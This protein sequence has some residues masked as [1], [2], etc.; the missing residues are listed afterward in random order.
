[1]KK[2]RVIFGSSILLLLSS[3]IFV[4]TSYAFHS[5]DETS[6]K[7]NAV[8]C[9]YDSNCGNAR[10]A[11]CKDDGKCHCIDGVELERSS[12]NV[13]WGRRFWKGSNCPEPSCSADGCPSASRCEFRRNNNDLDTFEPTCICDSTNKR[14]EIGSCPR[15]VTCTSL[16]NAWDCG[17]NSGN[18]YCKNRKC[19]CKD[20]SAFQHYGYTCPEP[21]CSDH[22]GC[23]EDKNAGCTFDWRSSS[24]RYVSMCRCTITGSP[25]PGSDPCPAAMPVKPEERCPMK[26]GYNPW[27]IAGVIDK[28][29]TSDQGKMMCPPGPV[30]Y[31]NILCT[32]GAEQTSSRKLWCKR[33]GEWHVPHL[34]SCNNAARTTP[35]LDA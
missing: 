10:T 18:Q 11:Y 13:Y 1:M 17:D 9:T 14:P 5:I 34:D 25:K 4:K 20:E 19:H 29:C 32:D 21:N 26:L 2:L 16:F 22:V 15:Y 6:G 35:I 12:Y 23:Y 31:T 7:D 30:P 33:N 27:R 24:G 3:N 8:K 28:R